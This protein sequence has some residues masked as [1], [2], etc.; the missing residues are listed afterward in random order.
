MH[1]SPL[2]AVR[3]ISLTNLVLS[4]WSSLMKYQQNVSSHS[5]V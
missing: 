5:E 3:R 4:R 1:F 2:P